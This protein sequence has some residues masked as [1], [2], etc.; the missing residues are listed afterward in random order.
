QYAALRSVI[1][2]Q[3]PLP[4]VA[5]AFHMVSQEERVRGIDRANESVPEVASFHVQPRPRLDTR[6]SPKDPSQLTRTERK[7]L[8][9]SHCNRDGHDRS[10]CFDLMDENLDWWYELKGLKPP[11]ARGGK[12]GR[13]RGGGRGGSRSRDEVSSRGDGSRLV[14]S[15]AVNTP[16]AAVVAGSSR[17]MSVSI[18]P[19]FFSSKLFTISTS[20]QCSEFQG[21]KL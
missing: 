12:T 17:R 4:S 20:L 1:L 2:A 13:S 11:V 5:R 15:N 10:M 8:H 21:F 7:Q 18:L 14:T 3:V 6:T 19:G 16:S 9:C